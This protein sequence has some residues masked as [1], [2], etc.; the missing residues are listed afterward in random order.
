MKVT[1]GSGRTEKSLGLVF[2]ETWDA[3]TKLSPSV[4]Q[5][6]LDVLNNPRDGYLSVHK[7][8]SA[9]L[10]VNVQYYMSDAQL[11]TLSAQK[12]SAELSPKGK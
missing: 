3:A 7:E 8:F 1:F 2:H 11:K 4:P 5:R 6:L 12:G 9:D 10:G